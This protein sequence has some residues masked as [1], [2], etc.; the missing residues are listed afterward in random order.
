MSGQKV[1]KP[2]QMSAGVNGSP[3]AGEV[4]VRVDRVSKK[5][6]R[7]LRKSMWYGIKDITTEMIPGRRVEATRGA[8]RDLEFWAVDDVSFEVRQGQCLGVIGVNGAGKTTILKMLNGL[9]MPDKGRIDIRGRV[10]ALIAL[11][12]GFNPILTGRENIYV[13]AAVL[14]LSR[15]ETDSKLEEIIDFSGLSEFIDSPVQSYSSG[16]AIRLGFSVATALN[17][18]VLLLDEVLAVG[19]AGFKMKAY[20]RIGSM[21]E[22]SAVVFVTHS[23]SQLYRICDSV[24]VMSGG[25]IKIYDDIG[26]AVQSYNSHFSSQFARKALQK[27]HGLISKFDYSFADQVLPGEC[28]QIE[29]VISPSSDISPGLLVLNFSTPD[30]IL[31]GEYRGDFP[32]PMLLKR[33]RANVLSLRINALPFRMGEY[34]VDFALYTESRKQMLVHVV[35]AG[36]I[37]VGSATLTEAFCTLDGQL[38]VDDRECQPG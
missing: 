7:D 5:F 21:L 24:G 31:I 20:A 35:G 19:D 2:S 4:V 23:M 38:S 3:D 28:W 17:P 32:R 36:P 16:M 26:A 30:G 6:C 37:E 18:D 13:N 14:G 29:L 11:G 27:T 25:Q 34:Y 33:G 1:S 22:D 12:A 10:A 9:I 15:K 8:L